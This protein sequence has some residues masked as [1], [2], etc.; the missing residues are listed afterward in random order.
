MPKLLQLCD[1]ASFTHWIAETPG[2]PTAQEAYERMKNSGHLSKV[3]RPSAAHAAGRTVSQG[4]PQA[5]LNLK[6][7]NSSRPK[8]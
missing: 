3:N 5:G 1:E 7:R 8:S 2:M 6:P 4:V